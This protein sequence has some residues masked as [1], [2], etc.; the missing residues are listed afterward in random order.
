MAIAIISDIHANLEA[1]ESVL[2]DIRKR[3]IKKILFLGDAVGYGPDPNKCINLLRSECEVFLAGNH[4][5]AAVGMTD[6]EYFN[7]LAREAII[8]TSNLITEENRRFLSSLPVSMRIRSGPDEIFLVHSTPKEP[9]SWHYLLTLWDAEVNFNYFT[10]KI[11]FLG[12]SHIPFIVEK[13]PSGDI[14]VY[15]DGITLKK[16]FRYIINV[17]SVGQP[18]DRDPRACYAI[19]D[20]DQLGFIRVDYN[21]K[22]TQKRMAEAGLPM[23][24]IKR[25]EYGT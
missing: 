24:L 25:L 12:H 9:E 17:G 15:R 1:L 14:L 7:E 3:V 10:E 19:M 4:D 22:K 2:R 5:R 6:I 23:P 16:G 20:K 13:G 11:C 18:R 8:W 21:I